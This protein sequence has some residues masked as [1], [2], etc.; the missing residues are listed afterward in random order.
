MDQPATWFGRVAL[1]GAIVAIGV[2]CTAARADGYPGMQ[3][4]TGQWALAGATPVDPPAGERRDSHL[5]VFLTG[6]AARAIYDR[7][8]GLPAADPCGEDGDQVKVAGGMQCARLS[9][10]A[11]YECRFAIDLEHQAIVG[12]WAC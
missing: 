10:A 9:R 5:R 1:T 3:P 11:G 4:L 6:E 12:G 8:P 7:L 2:A